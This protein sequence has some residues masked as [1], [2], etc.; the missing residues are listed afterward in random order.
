MKLKNRNT[1][2][3][4]TTELTEMIPAQSLEQIRQKSHG[5]I[6]LMSYYKCAMMEVETKL[7]VLNE[8]FSLRFDR[9]PINSIHSRLKSPVSI[10]EKLAS[11]N[12]PMT[13]QTIEKN[14]NDIAGVRVICSF[15]DDIYLLADCLLGQDDITLIEQKDYIAHPKPNGY[16]SLHLIVQIPIYLQAGKRN[17]RVEIQLRT[18]AMDCWA[19][20][21]HQLRYKKDVADTK[22]IRAELQR[23]AVISAEL[24]ARMDR[25]RHQIIDDSDFERRSEIGL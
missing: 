14:L 9:N 20:L 12:L 11:K 18:I 7:N 5:F 24:D 3:T 2:V 23:C 15:L 19:S 6:T 13:L 25:L 10:E 22:Q 4:D 16:R 1:T 17:M 8:E 21:E